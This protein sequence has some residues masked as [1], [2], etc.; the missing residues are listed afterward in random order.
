MQILVFPIKINGST[1]SKPLI[2]VF[3]KKHS[4][5]AGDTES[6]PDP[7]GSFYCGDQVT[8]NEHLNTYI[9]IY[10]DNEGNRQEIL[11]TASRFLKAI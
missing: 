10:N 11:L 3:W 9:Y 2:L 1:R 8:L 7:S 4:K 6:D 5:S